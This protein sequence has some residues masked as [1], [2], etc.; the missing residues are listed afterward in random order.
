MS[1]CLLIFEICK[2]PDGDD[3]DDDDDD[4]ESLLKTASTGCNWKRNG[5]MH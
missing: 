3:D 4:T 2:V 5:M 1:P